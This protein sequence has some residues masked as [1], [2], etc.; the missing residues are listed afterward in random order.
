MEVN[1]RRVMQRAGLAQMKTP[2]SGEL[3]VNLV[4]EYSTPDDGPPAVLRERS[5]NAL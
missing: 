4:V 2:N 5:Q 1:G 3:G